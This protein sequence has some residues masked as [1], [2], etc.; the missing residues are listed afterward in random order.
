MRFD[1]IVC[2]PLLEFSWLHSKCYYLTR[3]YSLRYLDLM[4]ARNH[5]LFSSTVAVLI[6]SIKNYYFF[7]LSSPLAEHHLSF[8]PQLITSVHYYLMAFRY[9]NQFNLN[10]E[11]PIRYYFDFL[12]YLDLSKRSAIFLINPIKRYQV[13]LQNKLHLDW[14]ETLRILDNRYFKYQ[15]YHLQTI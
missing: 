10:F 15:L 14:L 5:F 9:V 2:W 4:N 12:S 6:M 3:F 11:L 13:F 7:V 1:Q 8:L